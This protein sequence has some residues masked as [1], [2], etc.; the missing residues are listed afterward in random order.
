MSYQ[1]QKPH[2]PNNEAI[3]ELRAGVG[4]DEAALFAG[5]LY[6]MY[7]KYAANKGWAFELIDSN[8]TSIGGF[9]SA[10]FELKGENVFPKLKNESGVHRVQRV[11]KTEKGGRVHTSTATMAVLPKASESE[12][13]IRSDEIEVTFSRAGGPG[14]QNVNKVETAVRILHKPS[15]IV[16]SSR[17]E[18]SQQNNREKGMELLRSK[19]LEIKKAEA[20]GNITEER[21]KQI[22]TGDRSEKIRTYNFPQDRI[23]DHR[24]KK[25]WSNIEKIINGNLDPVIEAVSQG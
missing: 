8:K 24:I 1:F 7:K 23:T 25:S 4:G 3:V 15:G 11:P 21:R 14:G 9:K 17:S 10:V 6:M 18:R 20:T 22:G 2:N 16:V 12:M 19:L 5:E 13:T